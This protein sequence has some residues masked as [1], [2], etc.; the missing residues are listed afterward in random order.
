MDKFINN[1][2]LN[3][4][5]NGIKSAIPFIAQNWI[6][7]AIGMGLII[8]AAK[9]VESMAK[10]ILFGAAIILSIGSLLYV[11]NTYHISKYF[12]T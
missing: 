3:A 7:L 1:I 2:D 5:I 9:V 11:E 10:I 8:L 12:I 6:M 4:I